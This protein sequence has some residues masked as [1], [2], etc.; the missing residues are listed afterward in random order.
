MDCPCKNPMTPDDTIAA[1]ATPPGE[2]GI[3]IIR[4][5]G[6]EA[7]SIALTLFRSASGKPRANLPSHR[8]FYGFII[9]P[10]TSETVDEV[11]I[12]PMKAPKSYTREDVVEISCHGG[13]A[14]L[15]R[16]FG[17]A[18]RHGARAAEPG[19]FTQRAFLNG[20][21]DLT[22]AEAVLDVIN[23]RT[24]LA[25]KSAIGQL[26]GGLSQQISALRERLRYLLAMVEASLD[27]PEEDIEVS[28][29]E[30][31][32]ETAADIISELRQLLD[33]YEE[34]RVLREGVSTAIVGRPNVGKSSL[35][36]ALLREERAIVTD[37]PGTTRDTLE[38]TADIHG[39]PIRIIDTAG[40]RETHD[41]VEQ[42]GVR[43]SLMAL[44]KAD[45]ALVVL[46]STQP[47]HPGDMEIL[48]RVRGS[49]AIVVL[50]KMDCGPV[51]SAEEVSPLCGDK[52]AIHLSATTG[53][54]LDALKLEM[55]RR[56]FGGTGPRESG[57]L[58]R[59]RHK[60]ALEKALDALAAFIRSLETGMSG[61]FL[62][63]DLRSALDAVGEI[64]GDTTPDDILD[65][66]F[67]EFCI[68]K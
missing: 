35:L 41:V 17:L 50:N 62:A 40:I 61:E 16:V 28:S 43:R 49:R 2:G 32:K 42:E 34:G 55:V 65:I 20:R 30:S 37:I 22:Q 1:L 18:L 10:D 66:I 29:A 11:L 53:D 9:D 68:G 8:V 15:R 27:F 57:V 26:R 59:A 63:V 7:F 6:P 38:E 3:G 19:E 54:G 36:N 67:R 45:L 52:P 25:L 12:V 56:V 39:L 21:I 58:T 14:P 24:E 44:E 13:M 4:I 48:E 46:D 33:S 51:L 64:S 60:D 23:S 47:L 5:S 31:L